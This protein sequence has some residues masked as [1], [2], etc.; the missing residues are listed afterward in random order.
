MSQFVRALGPGQAAALGGVGD[1]YPYPSFATYLQKLSTLSSAEGIFTFTGHN[2]GPYSY[3][4]SV[5]SD[6]HGG[7]QM[8]LNGSTTDAAPFANNLQVT[9]NLPTTAP[10][11]AVGVGSA[12]GALTTINVTNGGS[13]YNN[14]PTVT[15]APPIIFPAA[16]SAVVSGQF[17]H[18]FYHSQSRLGL[19]QPSAGDD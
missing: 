3:S 19:H 2:N 7:Y 4:G 9:V 14:P 13:G 12:G 11:T 6:G 16:A 1:P 5:T 15:V 10:A 18:Q 17:R 8:V